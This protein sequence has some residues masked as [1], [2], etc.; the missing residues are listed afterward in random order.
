MD[1]RLIFYDFEVFAYD[2]LVVLC[3]YSTRKGK[4]IINDR[5]ML[6]KYYNYFKNDIW[7]GF[8]TR[9]YDQYI[10]KGILLGYDPWY[11]SKEIVENNKKGYQII[12]NAYEI[13]LYNFD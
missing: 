4:V 12:P 5:E 10:L 7:I 8:N 3:E 13:K 2:W 11:I 6:R 9:N 1:R